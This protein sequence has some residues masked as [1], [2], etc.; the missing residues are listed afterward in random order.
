MTDELLV[1]I[2]PL[3]VAVDPGGVA[4]VALQLQNRSTVVDEYM[5]RVL[6][7]AAAWTTLD[8]SQ[9]PIF[10]EGVGS[11]QVT[12][13]PPRAS[14]PEAGTIAIGFRVR[15]TVDPSVSVVEECR[16]ELK[17]FVEIA[18]EVSPKTARGRFS[19]SHQL[20]VINRGNAPVSVSVRAEVQQGDCQVS[21]PEGPL[22]VAA[23]ERKTA[24]LK[25]RPTSAHWS[26][27]DEMHQY[28]L[29]LEPQGG[30]PVNLDA[31][32]RQRPILG[33]PVALL[34]AVVL[35]LAGAYAVYGKGTNPI[36]VALRWTGAVYNPGSP[37]ASAPPTAAADSGQQVHQQAP[38][39]V[40]G[41]ASS[42]PAQPAASPPPTVHA[43]PSPSAIATP[44]LRVSP[45]VLPP[46]YQICLTLSSVTLSD[47]VTLSLGGHL[48]TLSW[49]G[50][51]TCGPFSGT[52]TATYSGYF[53]CQFPCLSHP[54]VATKTFS[55]TGGSGSY[56]DQVSSLYTS[57]S[58][59]LTLTDSHGSSATASA[60]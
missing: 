24:R 15:S 2:N 40:N 37:P 25:V 22:V 57:V 9:V 44:I 46:I 56:Q 55:V 32:T 43:A 45:I 17:P 18:G 11:V 1:S 31:M 47:S 53:V 4:E 23:G 19:A 13:R 30:T 49:S 5:V 38:P 51:G 34:L 59:K 21:V 20:R 35:L 28:R 3:R 10:P 29:T 16:V 27:G 48:H 33:V 6:G 50:N 26:G 52:I 36:Q 39:V 54:V 41:P 14:H 7:E 12:M 42:P 58:Y 8:R 60:T